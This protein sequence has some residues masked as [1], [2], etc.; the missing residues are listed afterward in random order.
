[1]LN[2]L[3]NKKILLGVTGSIAA[4]KSPLIVRELTKL[5]AEV[6]VVMTPS[7]CQFV[8]PIT[9]SSVSKNPVVIEMFDLSSQKDGAWHIHLAHWCDLAIIA[10]CSAT[11]LGK[12]ANGIADN[13]LIAVFMAIPSNIPI[14]IAPAMDTTMFEFP[15][16]QKNI[17]TLQEW[18]IE[19]IPPDEGELASGLCGLGRLA[20]IPKIIDQVAAKLA[21]SESKR[22]DILDK[23]LEPL[24]DAVYKD[25]FQ[26]ELELTQ[27]KQNI[28]DNQLRNFYKDKTIIV[29]AG[30]TIERIDPVR[31]ITNA[32]SGKMGYAIAEQIAKYAKAVTLVSGPVNLPKP[33]NVKVIDVESAAEMYTTVNNIFVDCDILIMAAAVADFTP[34][35]KKESKIKNSSE[36]THIELEP[37]IDILKN[38]GSIKKKDQIL[39]GFALETDN[40][41]EN[42]TKKISEKNLDLIVLNKFSNDNQMFGSDENEIIIINRSLE[43]TKFEKAKKVDLAKRIIESIFKISTKS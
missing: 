15:S 34:K 4:F 18:G 14:L 20:E 32:S 17:A 36:L 39:I 12:L 23:P 13:A 8:T 43:I 26:A 41:I 6:K 7:A 24:E 29:T 42:A 37:N 40:E 3:K 27:I 25:K 30:P 33:E 16:T 21:N 10:P 1:M 22:P 11:T 38:L 35:N 9:L 31:Y 19:I 5:G 28:L 2:I